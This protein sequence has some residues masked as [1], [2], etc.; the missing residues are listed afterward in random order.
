MVGFA[1]T[2]SGL[3]VFAILNE[4]CYVE[5]CYVA[6]ASTTAGLIKMRSA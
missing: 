3:R 6:P 5:G 1:K 4:A 2:L